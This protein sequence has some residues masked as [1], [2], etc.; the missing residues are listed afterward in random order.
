MAWLAGKNCCYSSP[1]HCAVRWAHEAPPPTVTAAGCHACC[2]RT[3]DA[4][5]CAGAH[6]AAGKLVQVCLAHKDAT[7]TS[8]GRQG[9]GQR[10]VAKLGTMAR[11][12][13]AAAL[14]EL[15]LPHPLLGPLPSVQCLPAS[16]SGCTA[17]ACSLGT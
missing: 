8:A 1:V 13:H 17:R 14:A 10:W 4:V 6:Q 3:W 9:D 15:D 12:A 7:C 11:T 2:Q 5:R 16:N